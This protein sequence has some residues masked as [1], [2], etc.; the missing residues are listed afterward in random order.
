MKVFIEKQDTYYSL[1]IFV[2]GKKY[3]IP[4]LSIFY[5]VLLI[6]FKQLL[7]QQFINFVRIQQCVD[8]NYSRNKK[9]Q[10]AC[11]KFTHNYSSA[12]KK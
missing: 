8:N 7:T 3:I 11:L 12:T 5:Q 9:R 1:I 4:A 6:R 10:L 2:T